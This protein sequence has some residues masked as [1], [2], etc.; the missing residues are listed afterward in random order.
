MAIVCMH[1]RSAAG[2]QHYFALQ[3]M[4]CICM[5]G[6]CEGEAEG[7]VDDS[8]ERDLGCKDK[9]D[10]GVHPAVGILELQQQEGEWFRS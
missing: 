3:T 4:G 6:A 2:V 7:S 8:I 1:A 10:H 9:G 5:H